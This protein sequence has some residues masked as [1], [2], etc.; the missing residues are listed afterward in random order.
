MKRIAIATFLLVS[1]VFISNL[2]QVSAHC[3]IPCGIY[4]DETRIS[5]LYEHIETVEKSMKQI[6]ELSKDGETNYNQLVRWV[7]NKEEHAK[8][9]QDIVSQYFLHQRVKIA[10]P[11]DDEAYKKYV[12]ELT[13]LHELLVYAMKSKQTTDLVF[14]DK[15]KDS[16]HKFEHAYFGTEEEK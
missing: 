8:K 16:L 11:S 7:V 15:M 5:L 6:E 2:S 3:E 13:S 9:I 10:D 4:G 1:A 12:A 14:I